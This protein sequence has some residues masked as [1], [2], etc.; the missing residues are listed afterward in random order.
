MVLCFRVVLL[1]LNK[2]WKYLDSFYSRDHYD[3]FVYKYRDQ[4]EQIC[5][6]RNGLISVRQIGLPKDFWPFSWFLSLNF[7]FLPQGILD[8]IIQVLLSLRPSV[9]MS[10]DQNL[11]EAYFYTDVF[12]G[13]RATMEKLLS[14]LIFCGD[15]CVVIICFWH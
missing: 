10:C 1:F 6:R 9:N 12:V 5:V 11:V 3:R 4:F 13:V 8:F 2:V 15:I 14:K 7:K